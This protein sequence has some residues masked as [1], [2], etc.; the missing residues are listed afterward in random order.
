MLKLESFTEQD[1]ERLINWIP[2]S[3]LLMQW[4]GSNYSFPLDK[5]QLAENLLDSKGKNPKAFIFKCVN[6]ENNEVIGHIEI[7]RI[8][9]ANKSAV[10]ARVLV[11]N[12][13]NRGLGHGKEM[14]SLVMSFA[15]SKIN[16]R[17]LYLNVFDFNKSAIA[18]Y[19]KLGFTEIEFKEKAKDFEGER[20]NNIKMRLNYEDWKK[21]F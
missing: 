10:I 3:R 13:K 21:E 8:D 7:R 2:D 16:L 18:V 5:K 9:Y 4:A 17:T 6:T 1:F 14:T 12:V 19:K 15:F 20:W 11:G